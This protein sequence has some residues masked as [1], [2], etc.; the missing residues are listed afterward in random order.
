MYAALFYTSL[1]K[2]LLKFARGFLE[3]KGTEQTLL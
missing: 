2:K 1:E 3:F